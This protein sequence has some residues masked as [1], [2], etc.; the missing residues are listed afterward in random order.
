MHQLDPSCISAQDGLRVLDFLYRN[1]FMAVYFT[2]GEPTLHPD[3]MSFVRHANRLGLVTSMTTNGTSSLSTLD[4]LREAGLDVLSVS[5]DHWDG[6]F[7]EE[8][9]GHSRI[10]AKQEAKLRYAKQ[11]GL[12]AYALAYLN[13]LLCEDGAVQT[14]VEYVDDTLDV[15]VAFCFP[16]VCDENTYRLCGTNPEAHS[17]KLYRTVYRILQLKHGGHRVLNP[18][19]YLEDVLRFLSQSRPAVYCKGGEDVVYVD[20]QG[21]TYPCFLR[22]KLFNA[23]ENEPRFLRHVRCGDCVIN[24][25]REPSIFAQS[26]I[27][28]IFPF[29]E[30]PIVSFLLNKG[31]RSAPNVRELEQ[32]IRAKQTFHSRN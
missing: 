28:S 2:G 14:F 29:H 13:P 9:R 16:T 21:N 31:H 26:Y 23:L 4:G 15:P 22:A 19:A 10:Q 7:C 8:L 30:Y 5:L 1:K 18:T 27:P 6:E 3:V 11:I 20:W 24:C 17:D 12:R 32:E 25:F